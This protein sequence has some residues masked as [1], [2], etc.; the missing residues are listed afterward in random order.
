MKLEGLN[1]KQLEAVKTTDGPLLVLAGAGSGKTKVLTTRI[2]YLIE[3]GVEPYNILAI[4]FTNKAAKEMKERV[5]KLVGE[6]KDIQIST[7]HSFGL[8][9]IKR[10]YN[11]LGYERNFTILDGDDSLVLVKNI[12]K[13]MGL[14]SD[15]YNPKAIRNKISGAKNELVDP[16]EYEKYA[17]T[18]FEEVVC[19]VYKKY[20]E[21][22]K[23]NN[24]VDFDDLLILPIKLF[25]T[26]K[27]I[28]K[29]YQERFKYILVDEYQDTNRVQY[30][31][32]NMLAAKYK[33]ICVVGDNDQAI[34][35][36]RGS[37]YRNILNFENDYPS[38]KSVMLEEN[39]RSTK[40]ILNAANDVIKNN[41]IRKD[42]N[43]S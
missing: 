34:Y 5:F 21:R 18:D 7:F 29:M 41:K 10:H 20:E 14:N 28:L 37:D 16:F 12:V 38:L 33:N 2:A 35:S 4:T 27:D 15:D 22:L 25:S 3:S 9:L 1:E 23:S 24:S 19:K 42:K 32:V 39:Y 11:L 26:F 43:L 36:W 13:E 31:L 8:Y 17:T 40:T 30:I 6:V